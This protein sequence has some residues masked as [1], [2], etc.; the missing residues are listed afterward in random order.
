MLDVGGH[1]HI[2][3]IVKRINLALNLPQAAQGRRAGVKGV[4]AGHSLSTTT[5]PNRGKRDRKCLLATRSTFVI[6]ISLVK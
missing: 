3:L 5:F 2:L 6:I 4:L 1:L